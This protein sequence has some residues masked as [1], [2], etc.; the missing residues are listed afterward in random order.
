MA[1]GVAGQCLFSS[2]FQ[3]PPLFFLESGHRWPLAPTIVSFSQFL[4]LAW[5]PK[6]EVFQDQCFS[7]GVWKSSYGVDVG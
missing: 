1:L 4:L 5:D 7:E 6:G 3:S 2:F